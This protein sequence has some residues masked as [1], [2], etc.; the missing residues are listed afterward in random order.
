MAFQVG[1]LRSSN[2]TTQKKANLTKGQHDYGLPVQE[3]KWT[4]ENPWSEQG[5]AFAGR[6][7]GQEAEQSRARSDFVSSQATAF[8]HFTPL[9]Y[10]KASWKVQ[11]KFF[12]NAHERASPSTA[13]PGQWLQSRGTQWLPFGK[14]PSHDPN[15]AFFLRPEYRMA[16]TPCLHSLHI[17]D[18][19][20]KPWGRRFEAGRVPR[21]LKL[22][23]ARLIQAT[24]CRDWKTQTAFHHQFPDNRAQRN[25]TTSAPRKQSPYACDG[26]PLVWC[27]SSLR[28]RLR[29]I[30]NKQQP[31]VE[32]GTEDVRPRK[33]S[34]FMCTVDA[35]SEIARYILKLEKKKKKWR[36]H[37]FKIQPGPTL[38]EP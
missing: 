7:V 25:D 37:A 19:P 32:H 14:P 26:I 10:P 28:L 1:A 11:P 34:G 24:A 17:Q 38:I 5:L 2:P 18:L 35:T 9:S 3:T 12:G 36:E 23:S 4:P 16:A 27:G 6:S 29:I 33:N 22:A 30:E 8:N 15:Q 20:H 13:V 31:D 21:P